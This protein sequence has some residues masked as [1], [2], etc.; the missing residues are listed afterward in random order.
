MILRRALLIAACLL[1]GA[2]AA[3][4][5]PTA[6]AQPQGEPPPCIKEFLSL[7]DAATKKAADIRAASDRHVPPQQA[8]PLF[9][10]FAAAET[11]LIKY[12]EENTTWCGI[13]P[14]VVTNLKQ[15]HAK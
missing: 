6:P 1:P 5:Q 15:Q 4:F 3:Q 2:A 8:C 13:P 10:A 12:A 9:N 11:K 14:Q 7:R